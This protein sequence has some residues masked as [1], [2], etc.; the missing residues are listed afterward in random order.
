[1][2]GL[3]ARVEQPVIIPVQRVDAKKIRFDRTMPAGGADCS[4]E[5]LG[6]VPCAFRRVGLK[7]ISIAQSVI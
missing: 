4:V 2:A 3:S 5:T 6:L 1:M 7:M